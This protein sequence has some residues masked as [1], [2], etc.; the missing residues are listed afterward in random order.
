M[1]IGLVGQKR[2]MTRVFTEEGVGVPVT[3][4]EVLPNVI[5]QIKTLENDGYR[6]IQVTTGT[7]KRT[8]VTKA[9]AGHY[10]KAKV[11][12]GRNAWEFRITDNQ[13]A[14]DMAVGTELKVDLF[15]AGQMIDVIGTSK[16]KGFAGVV[17]RYHFACQDA[18]HGNSL[19]HRAPGSI[20][21]RQSPGKVFKG[22]KMSG[23]MGN[24]RC[25]V[26]SQQVVR[27][28][29]ERNLILIKGTVPGAPGSDV[30]IR[31]AVKVKNKKGGK[32]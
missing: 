22:K 19:S 16:G 12:P 10:A 15:A 25:T 18:T 32:Q 14:D 7:R 11:E 17:K 20:G 26:M 28:D 27:V 13:K 31:P 2:G 3:V 5:T 1:A 9:L 8:R 6:A 24:V 21:Q 4:I 30:I 29:I 23:Q